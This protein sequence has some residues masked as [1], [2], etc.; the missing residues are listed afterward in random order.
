MEVANEIG[1]HLI[2]YTQSAELIN[3]AR[4]ADLVYVFCNQRLIQSPKDMATRAAQNMC[5][6]QTH[7]SIAEER[8]SDDEMEWEITS[9]CSD[10]EMIDDLVPIIDNT[11]VE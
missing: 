10:V 7:K 3:P 11:D 1:L 2:L 6:F 9:Q 4:T 5:Q 8:Q